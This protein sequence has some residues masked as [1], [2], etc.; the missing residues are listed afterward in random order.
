MLGKKTRVFLKDEQMA[1][2]GLIFMKLSLESVELDRK[3]RKEREKLL[4]SLAF[5]T[6]V[7]IDTIAARKH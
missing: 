7:V 4:Q 1:H 5:M 3:G 6:K 2:L